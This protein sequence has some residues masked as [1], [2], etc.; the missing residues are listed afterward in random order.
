MSFLLLRHTCQA[1][2]NATSVNVRGAHAACSRAWPLHCA[3]STGEKDGDAVDEEDANQHRPPPGMLL[4][5]KEHDG[6]EA[7]EDKIKSEIGFQMLH[8]FKSNG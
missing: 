1:Q 5:K 7:L 3:A 8:Q 6:K 4:P 2:S